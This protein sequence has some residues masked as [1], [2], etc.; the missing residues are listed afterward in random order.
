MTFR[1]ASLAIV[2][3]YSPYNTALTEAPYAGAPWGLLPLIPLALLPEQIGRSFLFA[4]SLAA[5][6]YSAYR[7]GAKPVAMLAFLISPP[8]L[9]CLLNANLDW[10]PL[11]GYIMPPQFGLFFLS[12]KPQMGSVVAVF[13]LIEAW[14]QGGWRR[15]LWIFGP[16]TLALLLSLALY[17]FW[18]LNIL[19]ASTYTTW[20]NAS[21]WPASIPVGLVLALA[22]IRR[23]KVNYAMAA[24]P[25][26]SPHVLLHSWSAA[27]V[28]IVS[29]TP[30]T[31]AAVVG[32]WV[33]VILRALS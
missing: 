17:G 5:F 7:L 18:P 3:G 1:P 19:K 22:A 26:L 30:E 10:M 14:R 24:S 2:Q 20:W 32:L 12:I 11:L 33:W 21:L 9:H 13:W 15:V 6:G 28:S 16:F 31:I 29:L 8:I 27:L 25:C 4:I 23:N